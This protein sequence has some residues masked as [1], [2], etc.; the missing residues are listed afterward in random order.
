MLFRSLVIGS[1]ALLVIPLM[2]ESGHYGWV[3]RTLVIDVPRE[4]QRTRLLARD[5]ITQQLADAMLA[6]QASREQRLAIAD[7]VIENLG[8]L[9]DLDAPV[10]ALHEHYL[11]LAK[12]VAVA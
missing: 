12:N 11:A 1:Y 3:D 4:V 9:A 8:T 5:G 7:D 6:A 10:R 2:V